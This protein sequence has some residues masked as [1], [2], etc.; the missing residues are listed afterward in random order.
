MRKTARD[1]FPLTEDR[2]PWFD[3]TER[4]HPF[5]KRKTMRVCSIKGKNATSISIYS[6]TH[7][8][9]VVLSLISRYF[10]CFVRTTARFLS[11]FARRPEPLGRTF[12]SIATHLSWT[13]NASSG[14][15]C[16][17]RH[18]RVQLRP[19]LMQFTFHQK[20]PTLLA[21]SVP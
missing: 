7:K 14:F 20:R 16:H 15:L 18:D 3:S 8:Q 1:V 2:P 5:Q 6:I 12:F 11:E 17:E 21:S 9:H 13:A 4:V 19:R 10:T